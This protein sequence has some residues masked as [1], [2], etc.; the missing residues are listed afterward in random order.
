MLKQVPKLHIFALVGT[1]DSDET[2]HELSQGVDIFL[3]IFAATATADLL[4]FG[5]SRCFLLVVC[6][7]G[8]A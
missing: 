5:L 4:S 8:W 6:L 1:W 2:Y 7:S 3:N